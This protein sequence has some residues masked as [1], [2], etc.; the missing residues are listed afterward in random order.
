MVADLVAHALHN[1]SLDGSKASLSG[2]LDLTRGLDGHL[3]N[4]LANGRLV[5]RSWCRGSSCC[6]SQSF[7]D[8][9]FQFVLIM[10]LEDSAYFFS[11][12]GTVKDKCSILGY[13][14]VVAADLGRSLDSSWGSYLVGS[15][16]RAGVRAI[17]GIARALGRISSSPFAEEVLV[18]LHSVRIYVVRTVVEQVVLFLTVV[19]PAFP[20]GASKLGIGLASGRRRSDMVGSWLLARAS[21]DFL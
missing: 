1:V 15:R 8:D 6:C 18:L 17:V 5:G 7:L 2:G 20:L 16:L 14:D 19:A 3:L 10:V 9:G 4:L 12:S 11:G 13:S 21:P